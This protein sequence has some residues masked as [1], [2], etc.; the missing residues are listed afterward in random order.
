MALARLRPRLASAIRAP[1]MVRGAA[2][3]AAIWV[4]YFG[5]AAATRAFIYFRF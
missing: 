4:I 5:A 2:Y 1:G 3:A